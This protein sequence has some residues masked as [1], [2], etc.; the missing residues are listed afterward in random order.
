MRK[1]SEPKGEIGTYKRKNKIT[2]SFYQKVLGEIPPGAWDD[3]IHT[4]NKSKYEQVVTS[5]ESGW[6]VKEC[7]HVSRFNWD[8]VDYDYYAQE[9]RKL[10]I[11]G[12]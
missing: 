11:G 4:K 5:I 3:R 2:D 1:V 12:Q 8:D 6:K 7:N 10:V 9:I